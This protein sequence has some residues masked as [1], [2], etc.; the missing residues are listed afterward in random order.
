MWKHHGPCRNQTPRPEPL[1]KRTRKREF[2]EQMQQVVRWEDWVALI[3]T[4]A[5]DGRRGQPPFPVE[6]PLRIHFM[7]QW[8][9][10]S[11]PV[12]KEALHDMPLFRDFASLAWDSAIPDESSILGFR[13]ILKTHKLRRANPED[14]HGLVELL[15][16]TGT[17][18]DASLIAAP[19]SSMNSA[20]P[21]ATT[22]GFFM[23]PSQ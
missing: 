19:S 18:V 5:P 14:S 1:P 16:H 23:W 2:L 9:T 3:A 11:D 8:F 13:H 7:H 4:Y 21:N 10:P 12:M 17:I 20:R 6:M 15:L 22:L